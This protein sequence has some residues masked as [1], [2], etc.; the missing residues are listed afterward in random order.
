MQIFADV[1]GREIK[2]AGSTQTPALGSAMFGAVAAGKA[3][4]GYDSIYDAAPVMGKLK[5]ETYAP[6]AGAKQIY[7]QL[8]AEYVRLHDYFGRG[9]NDVMKQLKSIK[10]RSRSSR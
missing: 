2:V 8:Y 4:G 6:D 10:S 3:R 1:T 7:D 9:G 5:Q